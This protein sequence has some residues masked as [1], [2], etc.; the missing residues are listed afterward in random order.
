[1]FLLVIKIIALYLQYNNYEQNMQ[2]KLNTILE[3]VTSGYS[4]REK[5]KNNINGTVKVIQL[6]NVK[7]DYT[8][9]NQ[10]CVLIHNTKIKDKHFL[11]HGDVLFIA[12]GT[13]N[14]AIP[15]KANSTPT[16]ASSVFFILK[17][18]QHIANPAY[19]AW[20]INQKNT[21][22]YFK[23]NSSGTYTMSVSKSVLE[24]TPIL[25]PSLEKQHIIA[26]IAQL[27]NKEQA[28]YN[29]IANIKKSVTQ[30]Q[31]IKSL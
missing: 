27:Q 10:N 28:L 8:G 12:K 29:K 1:M 17:I 4:F 11:S 19:I 23:S 21:Q 5:V 15:F 18:K 20:F 30:Y 7:D 16:I 2:I 31:L 9:I 13:K 14:Y 24:N 3:Q 22:N 6:K 25:L 26:K